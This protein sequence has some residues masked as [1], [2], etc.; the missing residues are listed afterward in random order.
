MTPFMLFAAALNNNK[1]KLGIFSYRDSVL[2]KAVFALL[3]QTSQGGAFF[4]INDSQKGM[5]VRSSAVVTAVNICYSIRPDNKLLHTAMLQNTFLLNQYGFEIAQALSHDFESNQTS[6][7]VML[8][9]GKNG[10]NGALMVLRTMRDD[11]EYTA[12]V[13]G[14]GQG[15]GHGH[16]DK[17]G[18]LFYAGDN[19]VVQ[20]YGSARWVNVEQ[21]QGGRYLPEN[22]TWAKQTVAHNALVVDRTSHF[23]GNYKTASG[24]SPI[25][26]VFDASNPNFQLCVAKDTSAYPGVSITRYVILINDSA[27]SAPLVIDAVTA[28]SN[29]EHTYEL[30]YQ[31]I[32]GYIDSRPPLRAKND[33][34][35]MGSKAGFEHLFLESQSAIADSSYSF[36]WFRNKRFYTITSS[37]TPNDTIFYGSDRGQ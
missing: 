30:P 27:L 33:L 34:E 1:P 20:D 22:K 6:E 12:V 37:A 3:N 11:V 24:E 17:L 25:P 23:N 18:L 8:S 26:L 36:T 29:T 35:V 4:P 19:E 10:D 14:T 2:V 21:K 31:F 16:F 32:D 7:S 28:Q 13:K 15:L 9:D 5:S